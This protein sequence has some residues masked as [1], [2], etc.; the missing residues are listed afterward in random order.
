VIAVG[1]A[2]PTAWRWRSVPVVRWVLAGVAVGIAL[3]WFA[4]LVVAA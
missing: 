3:A 2:A 1:G 4:L